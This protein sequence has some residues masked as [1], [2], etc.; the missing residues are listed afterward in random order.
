METI[1]IYWITRLAAARDF[2]ESV[3]GLS[4][5]LIVA[6]LAGRF[7]EKFVFDDC[8][9]HDAMLFK[10]LIRK[11]K[12]LAVVAMLLASAAFIVLPFMPTSKDVSLMVLNKVVSDGGI[13]VLQVDAAGNVAPVPKSN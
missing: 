12:P 10:G 9:D 2:T 6:W 5:V 13:K 8:N 3:L 4:V 11:A 1:D 7:I